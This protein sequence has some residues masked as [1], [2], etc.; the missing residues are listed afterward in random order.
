MTSSAAALP[1]SHRFLC[2]YNH[3]PLKRIFDLSFSLMVVI[4]ALPLFVILAFLVRISSR[5]PIT[6][7]QQRIGRGGRI[8][9]CLKFRSMYADADNR[10]E[11][12]LASDPSLRAE[13]EASHKLKKDPR[14]TV[15]GRFLRKTSLDE[16]PQFL[17]VLRGDLSVVGPRA[18][19]YQE[20]DKHVKDKATKIL[21][22]RPGITGL[23][24]V[25]GRSDT[26]YAKRISLDEEYIENQSLL[27][28]ARI[29]AKTIP[30]MVF[31]K[32]AY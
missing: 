17:N 9:K 16:L 6:Y 12:I 19:V 26:S 2:D 28:D 7:S 25:S 18:M 11:A 1:R 15:I 3:K 10:L 23:W 29:I 5:G 13:W 8:F 20:L 32:G 24:Q 4:G 21:S 14:V 31:S 30:V 22:I 27:L